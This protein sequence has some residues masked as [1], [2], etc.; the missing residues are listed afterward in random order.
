MAVDAPFIAHFR[1]VPERGDGKRFEIVA[2]LHQIAAAIYQD[3]VLEDDVWLAQ[4][5]GGVTGFIEQ[6]SDY[7]PGMAVK[8]QMGET[9]AQ[10]MINGYYRLGSGNQPYSTRTVIST[11]GFVTGQDGGNPSVPEGQPTTTV[12]NEVKALVTLLN[13]VATNALPAVTADDVSLFRLDYK[14]AV[15]GDR[16][17][18]FPR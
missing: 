10:L 2:S 15:W 9:P 4:P 3:L 1:I 18:H 6:R 12:E 11:N 8:P 5:G 17:Y 7:L 16:G 14:G 13:T